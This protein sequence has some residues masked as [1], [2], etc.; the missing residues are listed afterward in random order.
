[1]QLLQAEKLVVQLKKYAIKSGN[2][3]FMQKATGA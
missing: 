2:E 1:L 3:V